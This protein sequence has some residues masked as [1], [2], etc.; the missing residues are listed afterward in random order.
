MRGLRALWVRAMSLFRR[1]RADTDFAAELDTHLALHIE[2]GIR[3]GLSE[4]DARRRALITLGGAE[5]ARQAHR[6]GRGLLWLENFAQDLRHGM[7]MLRR[8][9]GFAITAVLTLGLGIGACTAIFSLV[10]A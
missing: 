2:D 6:D 9:P 5:Q 10:N 1:N 3:A 8:S 4:A 7:R